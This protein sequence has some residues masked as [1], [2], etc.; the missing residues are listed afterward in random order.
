M[1]KELNI[2]RTTKED[3]SLISRKSFKTRFVLVIILIVFVVIVVLVNKTNNKTNQSNKDADN[4][5]SESLTQDGDSQD[6]PIDN[7]ITI[8]VD[9]GHGGRDPGKI[10]VNK[11]EE[12]DVNLSISL[13]LKDYLA[14][15]G[16]KVIMTREDDIGLYGESD[17]NKQLEDLKKR[18]EIVNNSDAF[19]AISIHQNSFTQENVK[20]AQVSYFGS[21][22]ESEIFA[23]ILQEQIKI[24]INDG[25][26]RLAKAETSYFMLKNT[27]CPIVIVECG[28]LS[29]NEEANL[30]IDESYQDKMAEAICSGLDTYVKI[31]NE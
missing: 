22:Q 5:N 6:I 2:K 9:P 13:K 26:K 4:S 1:P 8:V 14:N 28:F 25:N 11:A 17:R 3:N 10:G 16:Y 7:G 27:T 21:S 24:T 31:R 15:L 29:N 30:L 23:N 20:G 18:V 19:L 12:K